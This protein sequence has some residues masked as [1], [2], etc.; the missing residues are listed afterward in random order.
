MHE[1]HGVPLC[2]DHAVGIS[3]YARI[4][5]VR[6]AAGW[7]AYSLVVTEQQCFSVEQQAFIQEC[8]VLCERVLEEAA[9][10]LQHC[11]GKACLCWRMQS[12]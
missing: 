8:A 4:V 12:W 11:W 5:G 7:L 2:L 3:R 10:L 1:G 9:L 6:P